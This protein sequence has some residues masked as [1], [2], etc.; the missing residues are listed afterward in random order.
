MSYRNL[1]VRLH[2][3]CSRPWLVPVCLSADRRSTSRRKGQLTPLRKAAR[4]PTH[5]PSGRCQTGPTATFFM[6]NSPAPS[7]FSRA[8]PASTAPTPLACP[9]VVLS[10][11][12]VSAPQ[13]S[14]RRGAAVMS[15]QFAVAYTDPAVRP[16]VVA[17]TVIWPAAPVERTVAR[18]L[19][20]K[21]LPLA[22]LY[23]VVSAALPLSTPTN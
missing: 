16:D 19:P 8:Q 13:K 1:R 3:T 5:R 12:L 9:R 2:R 17:V 15:P 6:A 23:V 7:R 22:L 14:G 18:A 10:W 4:R 21:A 11:G 20:L